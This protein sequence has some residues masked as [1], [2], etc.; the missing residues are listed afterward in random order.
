MSTNEQQESARR[1]S[2]LDQQE[3]LIRDLQPDMVICWDQ[4]SDDEREK[5]H[6]E[7]TERFGPQICQMVIAMAK[8]KGEASSE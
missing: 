5:L 2:Q 6:A 7:L 3:A 8:S 1:L 4:M